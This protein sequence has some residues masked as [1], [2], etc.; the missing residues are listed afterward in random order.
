MKQHQIDRLLEAR[1]LEESAGGR[2]V[3]AGAVAARRRVY[4]V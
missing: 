1:S 3:T 2:S 4:F